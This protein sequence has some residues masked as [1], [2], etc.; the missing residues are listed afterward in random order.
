MAHM[1][2]VAAML[3]PRVCILFWDVRFR[4]FSLDDK[5]AFFVFR[6]S[7]VGYIFWD[8]VPLYVAFP[9]RL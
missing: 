7:F 4:L 9:G 5:F 8:V 3:V 6:F 1:R 2:P